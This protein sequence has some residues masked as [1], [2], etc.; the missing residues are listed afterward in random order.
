MISREEAW[1]LVFGHNIAELQAACE[2]II[3]PFI[4]V[5]IISTNSLNI[6][7]RKRLHDLNLWPFTSASHASQD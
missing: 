3:F 7:A 4:E 6:I 5:T 1:K 2:D